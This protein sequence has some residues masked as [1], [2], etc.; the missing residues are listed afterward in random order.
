MV[1]SVSPLTTSNKPS[2]SLTTTTATPL[3][4]RRLNQGSRN[5]G[6]IVP[7]MQSS[8]VLPQTSVTSRLLRERFLVQHCHSGQFLSGAEKGKLTWTSDPLQA[9]RYT[10][11]ETVQEQIRATREFYSVPDVQIASVVFEVDPNH[12]DRMDAWTV[13]SDL[14]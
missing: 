7:V 13:Y 8:G 2:N 10:L 12:P 5:T 1:M 3:P 11:M 9:F 14:Q 6:T 4:K